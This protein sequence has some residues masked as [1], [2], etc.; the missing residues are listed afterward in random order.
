MQKC[1][2]Q[3]A[4]PLMGGELPKSSNT[5]NQARADVS[6]RGLTLLEFFIKTIAFVWLLTSYFSYGK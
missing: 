6:A 3:A 4:T 2:Y 1:G 5:S